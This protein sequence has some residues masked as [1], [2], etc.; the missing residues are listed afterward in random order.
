MDH[1][2]LNFSPI[3]GYLYHLFIF[4]NII[5][6]VENNPMEAYKII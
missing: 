1:N 2:Y 6:K 5:L 4:Y 3:V